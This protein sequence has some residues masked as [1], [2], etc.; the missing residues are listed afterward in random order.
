MTRSTALAAEV[1]TMDKIERAMAG[2]DD[3]PEPSQARV[4]RWVTETYLGDPI[5]LDGQDRRPPDRPPS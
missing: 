4:R 5:P 1:R 2:I 3:L